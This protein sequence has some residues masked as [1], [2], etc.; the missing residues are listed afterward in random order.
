M[1]ILDTDIVSAIMRSQAEVIRWLDRQS[2]SSIWTT[3]VTVLEIRTGLEVMPA[4]RRRFVA[5]AAFASLLAEE[6]AG[7]VLAFDFGAAEQTGRLAASR[8]RAGLVRDV[9]DAMIAG[10]A[11]QQ[12]ATLATHNVRHFSDLRVP[13]VDPWSA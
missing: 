8:P 6:F 1:I 7:R 4:G 11:M 2:P 13:V 3:A 12:N 10:I 5:E 9:R